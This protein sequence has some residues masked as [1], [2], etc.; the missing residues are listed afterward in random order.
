MRIQ[1]SFGRWLTKREFFFLWFFFQKLKK[2]YNFMVMKNGVFKVD[3]GIYRKLFYNLRWIKKK[4]QRNINTQLLMCRSNGCEKV[5]SRRE[6]KR[7]R[8][9]A[10]CH[11]DLLSVCFNV[12]RVNRWLGQMII[13]FSPLSP[14]LPTCTVSLSFFCSKIIIDR[15][16]TKRKSFIYRKN[17]IFFF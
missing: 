14:P 2:C 13:L 7:R 9:L 11:F 12:L 6:R 5:L 15:R 16:Q 3:S 1:I 10:R 8:Q 17:Y 4:T